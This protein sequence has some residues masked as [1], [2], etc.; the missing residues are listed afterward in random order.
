MKGEGLV[1]CTKLKE[2]GAYHLDNPVFIKK[3]SEVKERF[4]I[5]ALE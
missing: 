4:H 5:V 2:K 3:E 1:K